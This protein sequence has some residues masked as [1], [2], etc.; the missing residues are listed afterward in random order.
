MRVD[1][2]R[3][4]YKGDTGPTGNA[5]VEGRVT[6]FVG[7]ETSVPVPEILHVGADHYVAA[8]HPNAPAPDAS[9]EADA[10]WARAAGRG[11]ATLHEETEPLVDGYGPFRAVDGGV[12]VETADDWH[13]AAVDDVRR[14]RAVLAE[15]GRTDVADAVVEFLRDRPDAFDGADDAVCCHGWWTPEHVAVEN[16]RVACVVDF[17]HTTAAPGEWDF[18]RTVTPTFAA[19]DGGADANTVRCAFRRGYESVRRLPSGFE[20]RSPLYGLSN[21][22]YYL[23]SLH[24]QGQHGPA[25]TA[26]RADRFRARVFETISEHR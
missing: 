22:V 24:V 8:W 11:L 5:A 16:G 23:E 4:V 3:A 7:R 2:R 19:R 10:T 1:G 13:A 15:Y 6:A 21:A 18:W 20:R 26:E 14:R 12:S 17:E 9:G 25:A